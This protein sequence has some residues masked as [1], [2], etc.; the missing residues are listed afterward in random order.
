MKLT[1]PTT[2]TVDQVDDY[3]G[4][5]VHDPYRWLEDVDSP[6]TLDWIHRQNELTFGF[7]AQ[8]PARERLRKR[9]TELWDYPKAQAPVK[10]GGRTFQLR[11]SGLQNQDALFVCESL[12]AEQRLLLDPNALSADGTVALNSWKV[13]SDG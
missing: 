5:L 7:L 11:N 2:H 6:E 13:S 12:S 1:Y 3:H 4:T 8:I 9:L 10:R